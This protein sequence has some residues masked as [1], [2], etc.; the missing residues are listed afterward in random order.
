MRRTV[1]YC[2]KELE[3]MEEIEII[4]LSSLQEGLIGI[5]EN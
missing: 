2:L 5:M 1:F 3:A 4:S